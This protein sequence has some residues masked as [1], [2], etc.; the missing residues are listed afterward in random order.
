MAVAPHTVF[1]SPENAPS[2]PV[3]QLPQDQPQP[4]GFVDQE[5]YIDNAALVT[6][7]VMTKRDEQ[8]ARLPT[9]NGSDEAWAMYH[10]RYDF[11]YKSHWQSK[12]V[13]PKLFITVERLCAVLSRILEKSP[14]WFEVEATDETVQMYVDLVKG[15]V[16][17]YLDHD[18]VNF[19]KIFR[20]ALKSALLSNMCYLLV[21]YE[22]NGEMFFTD[23][24]A[25][26]DDPASTLGGFVSLGGFA[27]LA[28]ADKPDLPGKKKSKPRIEVLNPDYVLLD[29]DTNG[30]TF[31]IMTQELMVGKFRDQAKAQSYDLDAVER[32]IQKGMNTAIDAT[33]EVSGFHEVRDAEKADTLPDYR[34][35]TKITVDHFFGTLYDRHT[36][37]VLVRD[38]YFVVGNGSE[39]LLEPQPIPLWDGED[40]IIAA[41]LVENPFAPYGRSP[42]VMNLDMFEVYVEFLNLMFD[43]FQAN[44]LGMRE[45]DMDCIDDMEEDFQTGFFPGKTIYTRKQRQPNTQAV[46]NVPFSPIDPGFWQFFQLFQKEVSDNSLLSD[47]LGGMP[48]TRGRIT[49]ME[50][51]RRATEAGHMIDFIFDGLEDNLMTPVVRKLFYLIL[52]YMTQAEWAEWI[53]NNQNKIKPK[54]MLENGQQNPA[55]AKWDELLEEMK[56]WNPWQRW[57]K[58]AGFFKFRV[59]IFSALGDRQ[60]DIEKGTFLLQ[61]L[62]QIPGG[63]Q[64]IR[65]RELLRHILRAFGWNPVELLAPEN[66]PMPEDTGQL[67][68]PPSPQ[69]NQEWPQVP[70]VTEGLQGA[71]FQ[72]DP[73]SI[74]TTPPSIPG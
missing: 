66:V 52:Q 8:R 38:S 39:L 37:E 54:P 69:Q 27:Q 50:F 31:K 53:D 68:E 28:H 41:T 26:S 71:M 70:D 30:S 21:C 24:D 56:T 42:I 67:G 65:V 15:I 4:R 62:S 45:V 29:N 57:E 35:T 72:G 7:F 73:Q 74:S 16:K 59:R 49:A 36:G 55:L 51:N 61:T 58:L 44:L 18:Q 63:L 10:N 5:S 19:K 20:A 9:L 12:R 1:L 34:P 23:T 47:T 14:E 13:A 2:P 17:H 11:D 33:D 32:T 25:V 60:Q 43:F 22:D 64:S 48:R 40:P 46:Q 6:N 3:V